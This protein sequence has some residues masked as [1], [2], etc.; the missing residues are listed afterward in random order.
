M[1]VYVYVFVYVYNICVCVCVCV[2]PYWPY[3]VRKIR[4]A[5]FPQREGGMN[6]FSENGND[7]VGSLLH[8]GEDWRRPLWVFPK[9]KTAPVRIHVYVYLCTCVY[10]NRCGDCQVFRRQ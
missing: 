9:I 1:C 2:L 7:F 10:A 6:T 4:L 5:A 8:E 3:P